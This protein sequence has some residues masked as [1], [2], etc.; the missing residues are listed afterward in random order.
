MSGSDRIEVPR[1]WWKS[2]FYGLALDLWRAA[3]TID[4]TRQQADFLIETLDLEPPAR[5]LDVP[6]GNGRL[7]GELASRGYRMTGVDIASE[8]IEEAR[9]RAATDGLDV[10]FIEGDM[11]DL[12]GPATF[13]GSFC[14]GNSFGYLDDDGTADFVEAVHRALRPGGR[15][16]IDAPMVAEVLFPRFQERMKHEAGLSAEVG[17]ITARREQR[18]DPVR[19]RVDARY[20]FSRNEK[21]EIG[22]TSHRVH[23]SREICALLGAKGFH[24][25]SLRGGLDET[26]FGIGASTLIVVAT[27]SSAP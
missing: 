22:F 17:G 21:E 13:D 11:R 20:T 12:P 25:D 3:V 18:Y 19:G 2:F 24:V 9:A 8:F 5:I 1:E 15:F 16:I 26:P 14:W 27:V 23:T 6:C 10:D 7:C 4:E